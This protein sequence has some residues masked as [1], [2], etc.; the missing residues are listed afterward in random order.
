VL[1]KTGLYR[2]EPCRGIG[3]CGRFGKHSICWLLGEWLLRY[4][5]T[6]INLTADGVWNGDG[7]IV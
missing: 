7:S 3:T 2:P 4:R 1:L 6:Y 5:W